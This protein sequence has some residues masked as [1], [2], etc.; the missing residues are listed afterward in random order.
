M[1]M[2]RQEQN[3]NAPLTTKTQCYLSIGLAC[4]AFVT[5][6]GIV[7]SALLKREFELFF[8]QPQIFE[9]FSL[10]DIFLTGEGLHFSNMISFSPMLVLSMALPQWLFGAGAISTTALHTLLLHSLTTAAL[11]LALWRMQFPWRLALYTAL[12][13]SCMPVLLPALNSIEGRGVLLGS[14]FALLT[15]ER[16]FALRNHQRTTF[17]ALLLCSLWYALAVLSHLSMVV[18]PVLLLAFDMLLP[19]TI[20]K[21]TTEAQNVENTNSYRLVYV[22][23][24]LTL[25]VYFALRISAVGL[26]AFP[27]HALVATLS[28]TQRIAL[29]AETL[30]HALQ[31]SLL[32]TTYSPQLNDYRVFAIPNVKS[33][34]FA[35]ATLCL[36]TLS[37]AGILAFFDGRKIPLLSL[38]WFFLP[39]LAYSSVFLPLGRVHTAHA[40]YFAAIGAAIF[41][42]WLIYAIQQRSTFSAI[43]ILGAFLLLQAST[44]WALQKQTHSE[45]QYWYH[46]LAKNIGSA[47]AWKD[48][49]LLELEEQ[50]QQ[51]A[52]HALLQSRN[53]RQR[54]QLFDH[55]GTQELAKLQRSLGLRKAAITSYSALLDRNPNDWIAAM[56]LGQLYLEDPQLFPKAVQ[57]FRFI[58]QRNPKNAHAL[59]HE[60]EALQRVGQL[61]DAKARIK[62]ALALT[63]NWSYMHRIHA[64]ILEALGEPIEADAAR[65]K[66]QSLQDAAS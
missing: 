48:V 27:S 14:F 63:P 66:A 17:S 12:I 20:A 9:N 7:Q 24:V 40:G 53:L 57:V 59:A 10:L 43:L 3:P 52:L 39:L 32:P 45:M 31:H 38:L 58:T 33:S 1:Q 19:R 16:F 2:P 30:V 13:F 5:N 15:I 41:I 51:K 8:S 23:I 54:H 37:I 46:V 29:A 36:G 25:A 55:Q 49:A 44:T 65:S 4:V 28:S 47:E 50:N 35:L 34:A 56:S 26:A 6:I 60:A 64:N 18:L 22:S 62:Q 11:Y 21:N 61:Q 42:A